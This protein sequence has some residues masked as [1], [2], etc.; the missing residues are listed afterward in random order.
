MIRARLCVS[1]LAAILV[2][3]GLAADP[4]GG[5]PA[6]GGAELW[7]SR[8]D[9]PNLDSAI[10]VVVSPDQSKVFVTGSSYRATSQ[11]D[12]LTIAYDA[13]TGGVLWARRYNGPMNGDD[14]ADSLVVRPD[15]S[16]VFVTGSSTGGPSTRDYATIAYDAS[17]GTTVW[18]RRYN[19]PESYSWDVAN[20]AAASPDGSKIF[21]TGNSQS[22]ID[23]DYATIAYDAATGATLW[24][25]RYNGPGSG[26]DAATSVATSPDGSMAFITGIAWTGGG[27]DYATIAYD[28]STGTTVWVR[29]YNG[30][31]DYDHPFSV[32]ACPDGSKV[33]VT[34]ESYATGGNS[35]Y[36]YATVAYEASTGATAWIRRYN[37]PGHCC[38]DARAGAVDPLVSGSIRSRGPD[39]RTQQQGE[40]LAERRSRDRR[41]P[42][43]GSERRRGRPR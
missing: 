11:N 32:A 17:T 16:K 9:P 37:G 3:V 43:G 35:S 38:I 27:E 24:V 1:I 20:S 28:A 15:G 42:C 40:S 12:Y 25:R 41:S 14:Y 6:Q 29:R 19:G 30:P 26:D 4:A 2:V 7:E 34:G 39:R 36:D 13:S 18:V 21:V 31:G 10:S 23:N 33:L 8:Y 22:A 5:S